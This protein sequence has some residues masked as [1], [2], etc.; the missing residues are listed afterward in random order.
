MK[1]SP[2][3]DLKFLPTKRPAQTSSNNQG[4][5][6]KPQYPPCVP[7]AASILPAHDK[8]Q[9]SKDQR[10]ENASDHFTLTRQGFS[11][12]DLEASTISAYASFPLAAICL[13][14]LAFTE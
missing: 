10:S 8:S 3:D 2:P 13:A 9:G 14:T 5:E 11:T 4:G 12:I 7:D 1:A 6:G